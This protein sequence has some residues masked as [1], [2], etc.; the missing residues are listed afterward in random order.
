MREIDTEQ[1]K[2]IQLEML[3]EVA[4]FCE[5]NNINY[6]LDSGTLI[7]AVRHKGY[8]PWDDDI[9]IGMLRP[10]YDKFLQLFNRQ[11]QVYKAYSIENNSNFYYPYA[12]VLDTRTVLYEPDE[13]GVKTNVYID[14]FVYDNAPTDKDELK[15]MY[16]NRDLYRGLN[17]TRTRMFT[18]FTTG[19]KRVVKWLM[20]P[21]LCL[22]PRNYFCKKMI[23][24]SK[25]YCD[26][27]TGYIGNFTAVV[28]VLCSK[29]LF[30]DFVYLEFEG[31]KFKAPVGYD[32]WLRTLYGDY[33]QLPPEDK[34]KPRHTFKAY[35]LDN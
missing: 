28:E 30:K 33:M 23:N 16:K 21:F 32:K 29:E 34:R 20:Y 17:N 3:R 1:L 26:K 11:S 35:F 4:K 27:D 5:E 19:F 9:D 2:Q 13:K 8:I 31:Q 18:G 14:V 22:F 24:N 15:K 25:K 7:G 10:D 12:K 6:W